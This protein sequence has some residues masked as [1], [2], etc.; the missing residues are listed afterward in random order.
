MIIKYNPST[1][2]FSTSTLTSV[3]KIVGKY[4]GRYAKGSSKFLGNH[5]AA[6]GAGLGIATGVL[7]LKDALK[8]G[9]SNK[10]NVVYLLNGAKS[11]TVKAKSPN[12]AVAKVKSQTPGGSKYRAFRV[13]DQDDQ[14]QDYMEAISQ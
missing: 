8:G 1:R 10:F 13:P 5:G 12:E 7:G 2:S 11:K 3:G 6:I 9:V 4:A 14:S